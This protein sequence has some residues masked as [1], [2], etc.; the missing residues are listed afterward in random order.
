MYTP[1][2]SSNSNAHDDNTMGCDIHTRAL[3]RESLSSCAIERFIFAI[4]LVIHIT[5]KLQKTESLN[6]KRSPLGV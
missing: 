4:T 5:S 6:P 2:C 1:I 3:A